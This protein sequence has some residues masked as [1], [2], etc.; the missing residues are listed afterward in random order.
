MAVYCAEF[1]HYRTDEKFY[2]IG[3]TSRSTDQRFDELRERFDIKIK[4]EVKADLYAAVSKE[5]ELLYD[6]QI[7][8]RRLYKPKAKFSG[9]SEC[10]L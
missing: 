8:Q 3:L 6:T 10:F 1:T 9:Q 4:W 5:T 2:K 7:K